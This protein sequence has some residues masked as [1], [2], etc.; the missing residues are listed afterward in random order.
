MHLLSTDTLRLRIAAASLIMPFNNLYRPSWA[1]AIVWIR[2]LL[3]RYENSLVVWVRTHV[4]SVYFIYVK[5]DLL[6][7][8]LCH[9][10]YSNILIRWCKCIT[11]EFSI[12]SLFLR[13]GSWGLPCWWIDTQ[14]NHSP[15][16]SQIMD[17]SQGT[18]QGNNFYT[19][20]FLLYLSM[21][22]VFVCDRSHID[23]TSLSSVYFPLNVLP[24]NY[25]KNHVE[26][27][28]VENHLN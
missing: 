5:H 21:F 24:V 18:I 15:R 2:Y 23:L 6:I 28:A 17:R 12:S 22:D 27:G 20:S 13:L 8:V 3:Y 1:V 9:R 25:K 11:C 14:R 19:I 4:T 7:I 16:V 10:L 26:I